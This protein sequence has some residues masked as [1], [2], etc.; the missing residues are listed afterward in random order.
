MPTIP[1]LPAA[2]QITAADELPLSQDGVTRGATVGELLAGTQPAIITAT[3]TLLGRVSVGPGGPEQVAVGTGLALTNGAVAATGFDHATFP[4]QTALQPTDE[5]VLN[6]A[7]TP[8]RMPLTMLRGLFSAGTNVS[9]DPAGTI[10]VSG[11]AVGPSGP[12]GPAGEQG[13][14]G[15]AGPAGPV[16]LTG[17]FGPSGPMGPAGPAGDTGADGPVGPQGPAGPAGPIGLIGPA[18]PPGATG[19]SGSIGPQG[20]IGPAGPIGS[21]GPTGPAGLTG[22]AGPPGPVG[23]AGIQGPVG[24]AGATGPVGIQGP[25]GLT[26]P[27]GP[28]GATGSA[29]PTGAAGPVGPQGPAGAA[30]SSTSITGA[31]LATSVGA[32]DLVGISQGGADRAISYANF[33]N[34]RLITDAANPAAAALSDGDSF[35]LGQGSATMMVGTLQKVADYI[36]TKLP[37]YAR[38]R[39]EELAAVALTL[40]RHNR[41]TVTLPNG[42]TV[43]VAQFG[44]CGDGF[45]CVVMNTSAA[46]TVTFGSGITCTG[47]ASLSPGQSAAVLA[48]RNSNSAQ[49]VYAQTPSSGSVPTIAIGVIANVPANASFGVSGSLLN[50]GTAPTLQ[51]SDNGGGTW[52][53]LPAGATVS[54]TAFSFLHPGMAA[55]A[56]Q[57][58]MVSDGANAPR[59]SNSF[60]VEAATLVT[61]TGVT[62]GQSTTI[63][64]TLA[65]LTTG[66]LVWMNGATEIGARVAVTGTSGAIVAPSSAGSYALALWD[67]AITGTGNKLAAI[68]SVPVG[69]PPSETITVNAVSTV[70]ASTAIAVSGSYTNGTPAGLAWSVDGTTYTIAA[71]PT[72][73]AGNFSFTIQAGAIAAGGPYTLRVRDT[74]IPA[75][76][77]ATSGTFNVESGTLGTLPAFVANQTATVPFTLAGIITAYISWW[78]GSSD[79]GSRIAVTGSSAAITAPAAGTYTLRLYDS[80][81]GATLLDAKANVTIAAQAI[82]VAT[83]ANTPLANAISV[84]GAYGNGT[85]TALDWSTDGGATW[86]AAS[87]PSIAGGAFS[88]SIPAGGVA[89]GAGYTLLVRDHTTGSQGSSSGTFSVYAAAITNSPSGSAGSAVTVTF[90]LTGIATVYLVW[91][92]GTT[93]V[94]ARLAARGGTATITAPGAGGYLLAIYDTSAAGTG[95]QL[96]SQAVTITSTGP[97]A[98]SS[99]LSVGVPSPVVMFDA[100]N[101]Q[102]LYAD[103]AFTTLQATGGGTVRGMRDTSGNGFDLGQAGS[104]PTLAIAAA[105]G[106]NGLAFAKSASQFLQQVSSGWVGGLQSGPLTALLVFKI[107]SDA[108]SGTPY[109]AASI[110]NGSTTGTTNAFTVNAS[111]IGTSPKVQ[112]GRASATS[113]SANDTTFGAAAKN[114]L[115]K[116]IARFDPTTNQIRMVVNG[117]AEV[118][119]TTVSPYSASGLAAWDTFLLGKQPFGS[120]P[121]FLDGVIFEV[122]VWNT[123][124]TDATKLA[125]LGSYATTKWGS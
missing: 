111:S 33:L 81:T 54:A 90:A 1:Q 58:I 119:G 9:I 74:A 103:A 96:A 124:L 99:L 62:G 4:P 3:G 61:P 40:S 57:T 64:F 87:T 50:Y 39:V 107:T 19:P 6:S 31:P 118:T 46:G 45:E 53:P 52:N 48:V 110:T 116:V 112:A 82:G 72:I 60:N 51:Y 79:V 17:S 16:G 26:G 114:T 21:T 41:A 94:S 7:G 67:S 105:N 49:G 38:R 77:G 32:S 59:Q 68:A 5:V 20:P 91:M 36:N 25:I 122:N 109:V 71:S 108:N 24:P 125:N 66:Y 123:Y 37:G 35:W 8:R 44:D 113:G 27:T 115:L 76:V 88:F 2:G 30:G 22:A 34:G 101:A 11:D 29:G 10:A 75:V 83:P 23:P 78:N 106:R 65:G 80:A 93:E 120:T 47:L 86:H 55:Q 121:F 85:P 95:T 73:A 84:T 100:S 98:D 56:G 14:V 104:A 13:P 69:A 12:Q 63:G 18:G 97:A 92:Q 117:K 43:S 42:G 28:A 102:S 15:P 89:A 70:L